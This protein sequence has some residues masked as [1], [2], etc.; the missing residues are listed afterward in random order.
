MLFAYER[1]RPA[2]SSTLEEAYWQ[3]IMDSLL[4]VIITALCYTAGMQGLLAMACECQQQVQ[5]VVPLGGPAIMALRPKRSFRN[6][7][8]IRQNSVCKEEL[9]VSKNP[10]T[11]RRQRRAQKRLGNATH[12][13]TLAHAGH[14]QIIIWRQQTKSMYTAAPKKSNDGLANQ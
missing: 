1:T 9:A 7:R 12:R 2:T 4:C 13:N 3:H 11:A 5:Q 8:W 14:P 6:G 10:F